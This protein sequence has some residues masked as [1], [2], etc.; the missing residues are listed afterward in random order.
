[1]IDRRRVKIKCCNKACGR[2]YALTRVLE[3]GENPR[4]LVECPYCGVEA[5]AEL[6]QWRSESV[7]VSKGIEGEEQVVATSFVLPDVL[8]SRPVT[9]EDQG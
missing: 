4:L 9:D 8:P 7:V 6:A 2:T 3:D 5:V 1:M